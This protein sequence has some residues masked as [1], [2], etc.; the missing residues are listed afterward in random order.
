MV[1]QAHLVQQ[2]AYLFGEYAQLAGKSIQA[3]LA[4]SAAR[5]SSRCI[6]TA[7]CSDIRATAKLSSKDNERATNIAK[8]FASGAE[9]KFI[10][11]LHYAD[12]DGS[13]YSI[14]EHSEIFHRLDHIRTSYH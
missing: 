2:L 13:Y 1:T 12:E 6:G 8:A 9:D 5:L 4:I 7:S 3:S 11:I 14:L 10:A